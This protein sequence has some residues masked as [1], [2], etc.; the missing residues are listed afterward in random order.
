MART[1][2]PKREFSKI[3]LIVVSIFTFGITVFSCVMIWRTEDLS[4]LAYLIPSIFAEAAT[5]TAFYYRKAEA[6]NIRKIE[7]T[8]NISKG[9]MNDEQ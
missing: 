2:K 8:Q 1:R 5:G 9:G 3:I 7:K 4:P 6:E